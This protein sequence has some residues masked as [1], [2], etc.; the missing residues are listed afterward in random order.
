ML[1]QAHRIIQKV[2]HY[3]EDTFGNKKTIQ[4]ELM[5]PVLLVLLVGE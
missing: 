2:K 1:I 3:L 5:L 4:I